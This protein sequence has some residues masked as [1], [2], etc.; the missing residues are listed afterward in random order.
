MHIKWM[1]LGPLIPSRNFCIQIK[2]RN[3]AVYRCVPSKCMAVSSDN[4]TICKQM[5]LCT[6]CAALHPA[7]KLS[8][9]SEEVASMT[10]TLLFVWFATGKKKY[11][12]IPL[13]SRLTQWDLPCRKYPNSCRSN[14]MIEKSIIIKSFQL[15]F[16]FHFYLLISLPLWVRRPK[17]HIHIHPLRPEPHLHLCD[18]F[19][20]V[21]RDDNG[22]WCGKKNWLGKSPPRT[23]TRMTKTCARTRIISHSE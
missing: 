18:L 8:L 14:Q 7:T 4:P 5:L 15:F 16:P 17:S 22:G 2:K 1:H 9:Q 13:I 10:D 11:C 19:F 6:I 23:V 12:I 3:I 20:E 21:V